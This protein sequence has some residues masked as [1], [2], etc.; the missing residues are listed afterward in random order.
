MSEYIT[1]DKDLNLTNIPFLGEHDVI[2]ILRNTA[3][4]QLCSISHFDED[5]KTIVSTDTME[6]L[7]SGECIQIDTVYGGLYIAEKYTYGTGGVSVTL[8]K[9]ISATGRER[10]IVNQNNGI[11]RYDKETGEKELLYQND[12]LHLNYIYYVNE[13]TGDFFANMMKYEDRGNGI[14]KSSTNYL[15]IGKIVD[16]ELKNFKLAQ[17]DEPSDVEAPFI[18]P[19]WD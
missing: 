19:G 3:N 8:G 10:D 6:I 13:E 7:P 17:I 14:V 4:G 5:D 18:I 15:Y 1:T 11:C 12:W 9:E 2:K 16:G